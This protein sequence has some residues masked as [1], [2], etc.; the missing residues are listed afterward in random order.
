MKR[1]RAETSS[2]PSKRQQGIAGFFTKPKKEEEPIEIKDEPESELNDLT[3]EGPLNPTDLPVITHNKT[4]ST[5]LVPIGTD[6][7]PPPSHP[8]YH[9]PPSPSYNHPFTIPPIPESLS[10]SLKFNLTSQPI[11]KPNL[12]LDLLYFKPFIER[13]SSKELVKF[14]L[15]SLPWYRVTYTVRGITI[16]TPRWTTVFGKDSTKL[17]WTGYKCAPKAI[18]PILLRLMQKGIF[19]LAVELHKETLM[20]VQSKKSQAR[21]TTSSL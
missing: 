3:S 15:D 1:T 7:Y 8:S 16:N 21:L 19:P 10:S 4:P 5:N 6:D 13:K 18:P 2:T 12:A 17:P 9:L 11:T 14:L 20:T